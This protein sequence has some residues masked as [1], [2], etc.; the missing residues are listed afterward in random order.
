[1]TLEDMRSLKREYISVQ[2]ASQIIGCDPQRLRDGLDIDEE[3]PVN[4]R[5]YL[6]PHCKIG[7]RHSIMRIGFLRWVEGATAAPKSMEING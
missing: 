3:R 7:N 1:M 6:F 5:R 2:E 4:M